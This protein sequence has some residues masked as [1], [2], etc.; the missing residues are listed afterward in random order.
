MR[1]EVPLAPARAHAL[2]LARLREQLGR[3]GETP[4][5]LGDVDVAGL[6][7]GLFLPMSELNHLRQQIVD[8]L[9]V[10]RDWAEVARIAER[11][12]AIAAAIARVPGVS[13]TRSHAVPNG[14]PNGLPFSLSAARV[15]PMVSP[16]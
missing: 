6:S 9:M 11:D 13:D 8:E 14:E 12:G 5:A 3:M 1:G 4:F 2:D 15:A 7:S 10:R 16:V